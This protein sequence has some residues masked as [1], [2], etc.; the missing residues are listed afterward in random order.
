MASA[1]SAGIRFPPPLIFLGFVL[2]G[3]LVEK[4]VALPSMP[5]AWP[6]GVLL[7]TLGFA[8]TAVAQGLFRARREPVTPWTPTS[9]IIDQGIYARTRNPQYLGMA[10][11]AL[12]IALGL[13]S[14]T[15]VVLV[16]VAALVVQQCVIRREEAYLEAKFGDQYRAY[17]ARV[18]RWL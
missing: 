5:R 17:K 11:M 10:L 6:L 13:R 2:L 12:A 1:D 8:I 4:M 9:R 7:F 16:L 3:P 15:S 14:W 18:R